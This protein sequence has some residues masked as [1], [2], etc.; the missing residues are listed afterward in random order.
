[1]SEPL[2]YFL[3]W[4]CHGTW[5]H[6]DERGSVDDEHSGW[7]QPLLD[8]D[9][10][11]AGQERSQMSGQPVT[12]D[13]RQRQVV[14]ETIAA[15]CRIRNWDLITLNVRT[16]HVHVVVAAPG[17]APEKVLGEFKAWATRRLR[18]AGFARAN[19]RL[20]TEHGSTR[21]LWNEERLRA[22]ISYVEDQQG[23]DLSGVRL[24]T[25]ARQSPKRQRGVASGTQIATVVGATRRLRSGL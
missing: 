8:L 2:A 7:G 6:G 4:T 11:R 17:T 9:E 20:W 1:M 12:L 10:P 3:T 25:P 19:E 18:E 23:P 22:A 21:Y 5:L 24:L 14:R 16:N 15:H 13:E